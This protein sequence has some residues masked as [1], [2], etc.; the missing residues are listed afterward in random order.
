MV[1]ANL[2]YLAT[3]LAPAFHPASPTTVYRTSLK[4]SQ[5]ESCSGQACN[6]QYTFANLRRGV[7]KA[8]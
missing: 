2:T 8:R 6:W 4:G 3:G 7:C 5:I 1:E